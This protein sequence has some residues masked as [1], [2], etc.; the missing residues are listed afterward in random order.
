MAE[1][2]ISGRKPLEGNALF[3]KKYQKP[4]TRKKLAPTVGSKKRCPQ[5]DREYPAD[6]FY[7]SENMPWC[8]I[9]TKIYRMEGNLKVLNRRL[10]WLKEQREKRRK[11]YP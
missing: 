11:E 1:S 3:K 2:R 7:D 5:C 4:L 6:E 9:C 10:E 8:I